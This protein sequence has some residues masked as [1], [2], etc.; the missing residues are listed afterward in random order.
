[1]FS[2]EQNEHLVCYEGKGSSITVLRSDETMLRHETAGG[3]GRLN[4]S[5][6]P[7][8]PEYVSKSF[9]DETFLVDGN[10]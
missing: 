9:L 5:D 4:C 3:R 6:T 1:M 10:L 7:G 2:G 8:V